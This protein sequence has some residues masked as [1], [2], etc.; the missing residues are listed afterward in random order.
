VQVYELAVLEVRGPDA[1][2]RVHC[3]GGTY[4]RSIA[5]DLGQ[6]MG[7]G[8]HLHE[9]RRMASGEF[10]IEQARTLE[11]LGELAASERV[12]DALVPAA[13]LLPGFP[14]VL[15][16]DITAAQIRNGRNFQAS[17]FRAMPAAKFVKAV[18]RSGELLA[19]GEAVLP[20]VYHPVV[21]L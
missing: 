4:M 14:E 18:S 2:L 17:A 8:A 1:R 5:H 13:K 7:C 15:V 9:L 12:M 20:N 16:D 10:K 19:V 11:Q 3:S 6:A 21:V